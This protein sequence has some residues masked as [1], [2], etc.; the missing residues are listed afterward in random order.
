[1]A[2]RSCEP[3][4]FLPPY[5]DKRYRSRTE[6]NLFV[7]PGDCLHTVQFSRCFLYVPE[8]MARLWPLLGTI[9]SPKRLTF[10][11]PH[12]MMIG[13]ISC[14]LAVNHCDW[15]IIDIFPEWANVKFTTGTII[16]LMFLNATCP[17]RILSILLA[18]TIVA[19]CDQYV[20]RHFA[21]PCFGDMHPTN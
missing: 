13:F 15:Y 6:S 18:K 5:P 20:V 11:Q 4:M 12:S 1:M 17:A 10:P 3:C 2:A 21:P 7:A 9:H 19:N 14:L 8:S 16:S